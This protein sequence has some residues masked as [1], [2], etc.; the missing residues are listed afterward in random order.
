MSVPWGIN[1]RT[2]H[3]NDNKEAV[4]LFSSSSCTT[5]SPSRARRVWSLL[6]NRMFMLFVPTAAQLSSHR[7]LNDCHEEFFTTNLK[8]HHSFEQTLASCSVIS[9]PRHPTTLWALFCCVWGLFESSLL[10]LLSIWLFFLLI[11]RSRLQVYCT[12][13]E[14]S[15]TLMRMNGTIVEKVPASSTFG[16]KSWLA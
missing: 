9:P 2:T 8:V 14:I 16:N 7:W 15:H 4:H 3:T 11:H 1:K 5:W 6:D 12:Q 10:F 13:G